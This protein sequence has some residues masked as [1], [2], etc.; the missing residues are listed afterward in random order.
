M[1]LPFRI[2]D[3]SIQGNFDYLVSKVLGVSGTSVGIRFG[4]GTA[5]WPGGSTFSTALPITHGLGKTPTV[6]FAG[7]A[8]GGGLAHIPV[9]AAYSPGATSFNVVAETGDLS[10]PGA[11]TTRNF[12]WVAIG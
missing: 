8:S 11:G 9:W 2:K 4:G 7:D 5:T 1:S 3:K 10:I 6:T 12:Y